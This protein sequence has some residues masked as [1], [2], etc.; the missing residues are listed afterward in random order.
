MIIINKVELV[1]FMP[2]YSQEV[3]LNPQVQGYINNINSNFLEARL[4]SPL[5]FQNDTGLV[6]AAW[7]RF[8]TGS[9]DQL[10]SQPGGQG[11]A[12]Q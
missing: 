12:C 10:R 1:C 2:V 6:V 8:G 7:Q 9:Y 11:S 5:C 3:I 4:E